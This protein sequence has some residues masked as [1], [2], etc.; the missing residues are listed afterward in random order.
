M[1][2]F[3]DFDPGFRPTAA[4]FIMF[5]ELSTTKLD[6]NGYSRPT[7]IVSLFTLRWNS[8]KTLNS[9]GCPVIRRNLNPIYYGA[10]IDYNWI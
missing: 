5:T 6:L 2:Y 9:L 4:G 8:V 10:T 7:S 3:Q 1:F